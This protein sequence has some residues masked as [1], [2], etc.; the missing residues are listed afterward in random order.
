MDRETKLERLREMISEYSFRMGEFKLASGGSSKYFYDLKQCVCHPEGCQYIADL[1]LGFIPKD[2]QYVGGMAE[3]AIP[4]MEAV[5]MRSWEVREEQQRTPLKGFWVRKAAKLTGKKDLIAGWVPEEG[6]KVAMVEDVTTTG[7]SLGKAL[8][9][10]EEMGVDIVSVSTIVDRQ[11][12]GREFFTEKGY[13]LKSIFQA[14]VFIREA[15]RKEEL[16]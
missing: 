1:L 11:E 5:M 4:I 10:L 6:A 12:G 14:E 8:D 16:L 9:V 15:K 2:T 13:D 7:G 3:G